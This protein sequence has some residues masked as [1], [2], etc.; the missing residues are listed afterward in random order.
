MD[1]ERNFSERLGDFLFEKKISSERFAGEIGIDIS[2]IYRYLRKESVPV[3]KNAIKIADYFSCSIDFLFGLTEENYNSD[4]RRAQPFDVCFKTALE[5]ND[6]TRY[7][8]H[9][10]TGISDQRLDDWYHGKRVPT[11]ENV[12][13][14]A[15]YFKC[16]ADSLLLR[17]N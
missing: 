16:T 1:I 15:N 8:V 5:K 14:L 13:L 3:L 4:Y 11:V 7:R 6:R 17:E 2:N 10:D 9:K 12:I